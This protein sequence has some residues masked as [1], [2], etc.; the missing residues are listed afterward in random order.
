MQSLLWCFFA[1]RGYLTRQEYALAL[2]VIV[3]VGS[4]IGPLISDMTIGP[5]NA[6]EVWLRSELDL[7]RAR[8][9]L[10]GYLLTA[11]PTL[12]VQIKRLRHIGYPPQYLIGANVALTI[13]LLIAPVVAICG[14]LA[15][16]LYLFFAKGRATPQ[17]DS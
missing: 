13:V 16:S 5:T 4:L 8:A 10:V 15:G 17:P 3:L 14:F 2:L 11:W 12:V 6:G 7:A 9:Q 1:W